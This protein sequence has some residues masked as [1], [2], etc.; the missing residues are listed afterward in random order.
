MFLLVILPKPSADVL[1]SVPKCRKAG[2]C[3]MEKI[4]MLDKLH[5]GVSY[6]DLGCEF[7]VSDQQYTLNKVSLNRNTL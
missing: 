5:L 2:M 3:F 7:N 1:S 6:S 4:G